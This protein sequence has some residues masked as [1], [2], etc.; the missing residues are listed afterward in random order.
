MTKSISQRK[1]AEAEIR[2]RYRHIKG[3]LT[4]I[5]HPFPYF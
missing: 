5:P 1:E 4:H 2:E 3:T